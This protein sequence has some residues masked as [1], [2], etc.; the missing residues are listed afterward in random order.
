MGF[1]PSY[2]DHFTLLVRGRVQKYVQL[3]SKIPLTFLV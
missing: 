2:V 3:S 1:S